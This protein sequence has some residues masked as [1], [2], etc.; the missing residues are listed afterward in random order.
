M[1][2]LQLKKFCHAARTGNFA[3][4]AKAFGVPPS[5]I[6]QTVR[7]LEQ[8]LDTPLFTRRA[9]AVVLNEQGAEFAR[10]VSQ[11]L[12]LLED[13]AAAARDDDRRG[14]VRLCVN[15]NRRIVM[16]TVEAFSRLYPEVDITARVSADPTAGTFDLIVSDRDDRLAAFRSEKLLSEQLAVAVGRRSPWAEATRLAD[17]AEAPFITMNEGSSLYR[18]THRLCRQAG[19]APRVAVQ[20]DDPYY[21]RKCVELGLGA[22][23]VPL[24]SWQGQFGGEVV[25]RPLDCRRDT[26]LYT[27]PDR[28]L[29]RCA[30]SFAR[31]LA[32]RCGQVTDNR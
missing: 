19:F 12:A 9:N 7:R 11:A 8:E 29:P 28:Y 25:L 2:L 15:T 13:A 23:V 24:F 10:R 21:V 30:R 31:M 22:A 5:D 14:A 17:L 20:S 1:E 16:D 26:F 3:R 18:L 4:T 32:Q 6:S 27:A